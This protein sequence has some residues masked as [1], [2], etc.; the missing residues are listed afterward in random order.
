MCVAG[1]W[2]LVAPN[3]SPGEVHSPLADHALLLILVLIHQQTKAHNPYRTSLY[4]FSDERGGKGVSSFSIS[5][6][7]LYLTLCQWVDKTVSLPD[8]HNAV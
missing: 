8:K 4:T 2:S 5:L 6:E 1:L 3:R 7:K